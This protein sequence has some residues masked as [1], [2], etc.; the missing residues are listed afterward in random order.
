MKKN[1][2]FVLFSI[3]IASCASIPEN[4]NVNYKKIVTG[5]GPEDLEIDSSAGFPRLL[6]SCNARRKNDAYFGEIVAV[7]LLNDSA[8][9]LIR[10][11]EPKDLN[12]NPHGICL[13]NDGKHAFIYAI[14]H[15]DKNK[16]HYVV[17]YLIGKDNLTFINAYTNSLLVSPNAVAANN[18]GS[19]WVGNDC[20]K[21]GNKME[22]LFKLKKSNVLYCNGNKNWI[23]AT[24][25]LA[26]ANGIV[27]KD[28]FVYLATTIQNTVFRFIAKSDGT[29]TKREEIIKIKG[30]DNLRFCGNNLLLPVHLRSFAF[31]K[32]A[33]DEK[34]KSPTVVYLIDPI[35]K[36]KKLIYSDDGR[37]ISAGST[38]L[39][40]GK[41]LYIA[42]IFDDF[43]L[44]AELK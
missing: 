9:T 35:N 3:I 24:N 41:Y 44:K 22:Y 13:T 8:K 27:I 17:K 16:K 26:F 10:I 21:R 33:T 4:T 25:K 20:G 39:V 37:I 40:Y 36:S 14:S 32:H 31:I 28:S 11:G 7:N 38:A 1:I 12:F 43:I 19:F 5:K 23:I 15:D 29:L 2:F 6:V 18:N 34:K 30:Q 42:Q